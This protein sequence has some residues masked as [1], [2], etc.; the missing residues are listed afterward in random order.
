DRDGDF[1]LSSGDIHVRKVRP[2]AGLA[3]LP[4]KAVASSSLLRWRGPDRDPSAPLG[5]QPSLTLE[6]TDGLA[7]RVPAGVVCRH[8][9]MLARQPAPWGQLPG[10]NL[11]TQ[12]VSNLEV[13]RAVALAIQSLGQPASPSCQPVNER[14]H[15]L[16][17]RLN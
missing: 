5:V 13:E 16:S 17:P 14:T 7:D 4:G 2:L 9:R 12:L 11:L 8:Q 1:R 10:H 15:N 3:V 6:H